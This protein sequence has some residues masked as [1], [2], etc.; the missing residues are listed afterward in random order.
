MNIKTARKM[1]KSMQQLKKL[2]SMYSATVKNDLSDDISSS[3]TV[4]APDGKQWKESGSVHMTT[5][6]FHKRLG[7]ETRQDAI[8]DLYERIQVGLED[9]SEEN[10]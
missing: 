7:N 2:A 3:I 9:L 1:K 6:Y 4:E 5:Q 8:N 10:S